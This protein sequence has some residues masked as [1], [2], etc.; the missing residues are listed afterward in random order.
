M[1]WYEDYILLN[2]KKKTCEVENLLIWYGTYLYTSTSLFSV[3]STWWWKE[4][5][6]H[7]SEIQTW[8]I[9]WNLKPTNKNVAIKLFPP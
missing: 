8:Y 5:E 3:H 9:S 4:K 6:F 2:D 7:K 1:Q